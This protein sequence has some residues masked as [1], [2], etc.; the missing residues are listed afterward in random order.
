MCAV[1]RGV[2]AADLVVRASVGRAQINV[3][4][5]A[6]LHPESNSDES[7]RCTSGPSRRLSCQ[8]H[9]DLAI[10]KRRALNDRVCLTIWHVAIFHDLDRTL[11]LVFHLFQFDPVRRQS[12]DALRGRHESNR[13]GYE[14]FAHRLLLLPSKLRAFETSK[15][16]L[17]SVSPSGK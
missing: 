7:P 3:L 13:K 15:S 12:T 11:A 2:I 16:P 17:C 6:V 8:F 4:E 5:L 10:V 9:R 14:K 1:L